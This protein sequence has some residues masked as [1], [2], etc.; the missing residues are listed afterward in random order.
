MIRA[1]LLRPDGTEG[2]CAFFGSVAEARE[3]IAYY[4]C[5]RA[6][7]GYSSVIEVE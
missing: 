7:A 4:L 3:W 1:T 5:H 2:L 6:F